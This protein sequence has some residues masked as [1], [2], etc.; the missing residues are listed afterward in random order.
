MHFANCLYFSAYTNYDFDKT[1][2]TEMDCG[3]Q[4]W[5][6]LHYINFIYRPI[7]NTNSNSIINSISK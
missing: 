5:D 1:A 4:T 3:N 2:I 6:K 7:T